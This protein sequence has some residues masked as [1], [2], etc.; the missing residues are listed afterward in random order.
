MELEKIIP[1]IIILIVII[2]IASYLKKRKDCKKRKKQEKNNKKALLKKQNFSKKY[3]CTKCG[4]LLNSQASFSEDCD[5]FQCENCFAFV[6]IDK[7]MKKK[8][9]DEYYCKNCGAI[10]NNMPEFS[11]NHPLYRCTECGEWCVG[12]TLKYPDVIWFCDSCNA[13]LNQQKGFNP[14]HKYHKCTSCGYKNSLSED[15]II[16]NNQNIE[17]EYEE[18]EEPIV[19]EKNTHVEKPNTY[20]EKHSSTMDELD[21][22]IGLESV[23]TQVKRMRAV[24]KKNKGNTE[25]I[26]LHMCFYGNPGTG[27]TKVARLIAKILYETG[28]L[29]TD[30][31]VETDRSGLCGQ[32]IGQTGPQT[33]AKVEEAMG[34]VLFIDEAYTLCNGGEK[35]YGHEAI[36]TLLKDMEDYN[37]KFCVILAGYRKE[38]EAMI[39]MNPGF[40]SRIN[41]KIDFPDYTIDEMVQIATIMLNNMDYTIETSA[42]RELYNIFNILSNRRN[43]ANART[44]RNVLQ[45]LID[46]Q[47]QRTDEDNNKYNDDEKI[48]KSIDVKLFRDENQL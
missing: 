17:K 14:K 12:D 22:L 9:Y 35:D 24:L 36:A 19:I 31:L 13:L 8:Y 10:L 18:I 1:G 11:P 32:Y 37:G 26:N 29:P 33:H 47:A 6:P 39:A 16:S 20:E 25:N 5:E 42:K 21:S 28:I 43:F 34:G 40:D 30:K 15:N 45:Q 41:R 48:I 46:I 7:H 44:V 23:K 38:M 3:Y 4:S 2:A 27:K